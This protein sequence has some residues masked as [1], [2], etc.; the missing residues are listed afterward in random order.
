MDFGNAVFCTAVIRG[1]NFSRL[2]RRRSKHRHR[3]L[4]HQTLRH[5]QQ[6]DL[7]HPV[8]PCIGKRAEEAR[9]DD[10]A[11]TWGGGRVRYKSNSGW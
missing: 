9:A 6:D 4:P 10:D 3:A 1:T 2:R 11:D 5:R 8:E 7:E